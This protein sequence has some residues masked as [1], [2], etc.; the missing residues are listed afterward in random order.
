MKFGDIFFGLLALIIGIGAM[1]TGFTFVGILFLGMLAAIL[2]YTLVFKSANTDKIIATNEASGLNTNVYVKKYDEA[3]IEK[4]KLPIFLTG[5]LIASAFTFM[6]FNWA[7]EIEPAADLGVA[8]F[9]DDQEILPPQTI[10]RPPPPPPP[11]P[12]PK[13]EVVEDE[14]I[15]EEEE[16]EIE[17]TEADEET[18]IE[19]PEVIEEPGEVEIEIEEEPEEPEIFMIVE[20][21]AVFPGGQLELMKFMA[22]KIKYPAIARE[23]SI[24]GRVIVKFVVNED[25]SISQE[26]VLRDIG[27]GCGDEALRVVRMMP[28]WAP[29]KQRGKPVKVWFTMPVAFKLE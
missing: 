28:K 23:N 13:L 4:F 6:A 2:I 29:G 15:I 18:E 21:N 8:D 12:P 19:V 7:E 25:G 24:E 11:P 1:A 3:N 22:N 16:I 9:E 27:G 26:Q 5:L 10:Q 17:E 20:E 14:E